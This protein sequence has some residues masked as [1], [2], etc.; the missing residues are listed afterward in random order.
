MSNDG[1]KNM[2][3]YEKKYGKNFQKDKHVTFE[4]ILNYV[5]LILRRQHFQ[6]NH[7]IFEDSLLYPNDALLSYK[8]FEKPKELILRKR[9]ESN[10]CVLFQHNFLPRQ[11]YCTSKYLKSNTFV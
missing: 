1:P 8:K 9:S 4:P 10:F 2:E 5:A 6:Q 3:L 11:V 7:Y